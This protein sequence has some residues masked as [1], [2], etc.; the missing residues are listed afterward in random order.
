MAISQGLLV[1][2]NTLSR[3]GRF[4][5]L[6]FAT[7]LS[8][9]AVHAAEP[10]PSSNWPHWRGPE[11]NGVAPGADPPIEW[12]E[13]KNIQWKVALPGK[14]SATPILW[15]D[16]L[17]VLSAVETDR[18]ADPADRPQRDPTLEAKTEAPTK[19]YQFVVQSFDRKTGKQ[20]WSHTA[21][22]AVP[23][24]GLHQTNTYAAGSPTTDGHRLYV[25]FGSRGNFCYSLDGKLLW[26]RDLGPI[27]SR[28]G[29]GEAVTPVV[30]GDS[31][32]LNWDQEKD[33]VL[34]CLDVQT[35]Q[36]RWKVD[37][38][39]KTSWNTPLVV[40]HGGKTQAIL[41][42]TTR[43]RSYDLATGEVLWQT[44]GMTVNAIPS[45]VAADGVVYVMSG[46][47]GA[48]A[49]AV[50]LDSRGELGEGQTVWRY[51]KGTPYVPSPL[52]VGGR[53]YFTMANVNAM[54]IL[55]AKT[56]QA[57]V[58]RG[59]LDGIKNV[60]GSPIAA[61]GRIYLADREGT[62]VVLKLSDKIEVLATNKLD[63]QFDASP[64]AVGKQLF[65]RGHKTLY[66]ISAPE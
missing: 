3:A 15:G 26:K 39:E 31:L 7:A 25:S 49:V 30:H 43:V 58:D 66:A 38:D 40:Q 11:A 61:A 59:R 55:D 18:V 14:G 22:E 65:L 32:L 13:D 16:Q 8:W 29:W 62:T 12:S 36:T 5:L 4:S 52:L 17:F 47:R 48:D 1:S 23:H 56:G 57:L 28:L 60:Y 44:G 53:L 54:T 42:G 41:N 51:S 64:V 9:A 37:R 46:Y 21:A 10:A 35:G 33:S 63:E 24:E 50:S 2:R 19:Y 27:H 34:Y 20:L 6:A 45:P